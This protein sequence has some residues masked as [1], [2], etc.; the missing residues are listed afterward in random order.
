VAV[1]LGYACINLTLGD[2]GN[3][4]TMLKKSWEKNGIAKA[5]WCGLQNSETLC[6]VLDWNA[7]NGIRLYRMTSNLIP[8]MSEFQLEQLPDWREIRSNFELAGELARANGIRLSFHPGQFNC[9]GSLT[10]TTVDRSIV[11][12]E[13]HG[14]IMDL[15][16]MPRDRRAKINIH[17]GG[18]HGDKVA[19][20]ERWCRSFDRLS[21]SVKSRITLENDDK[22]NGYSTKDLYELVH[23]KTGVPI[24]F[25]YHHHRFCNGGLSE[26]EALGLAVSTWG[27]IKPTC[28]YSE[29]RCEKE[30]EK[31]PPAAHSDYVYDFINDHGYDL[32]IMI[33]AKAKELAVFK[34]VNDHIKK[35]DNA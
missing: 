13:C 8:W 10:E 9:L 35:E 18:V 22:A 27:D 15:M 2:K 11:D 12:L 3:V 32:D 21:D 7:S 16:G 24:V 19:T 30:G 4:R 14:T 34:Y 29:S 5:S 33:E 1:N 26:R 23:K 28:H 17:I 6:R 20:T 25:D 31:C